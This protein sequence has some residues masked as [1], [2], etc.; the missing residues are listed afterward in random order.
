[1]IGY[2]ALRGFCDEGLSTP[3]VPRGIYADRKEAHNKGW[4]EF[5]QGHPDMFIET[6]EV[7]VDSDPRVQRLV[8]AA[9]ALAEFYPVPAPDSSVGCLLAALEP[10]DA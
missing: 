6:L 4:M 5:G 9:R 7:E 1:M 8:S 3:S 2:F 10:F